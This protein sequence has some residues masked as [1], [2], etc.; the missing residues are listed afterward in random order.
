MSATRSVRFSRKISSPDTL[1]FIN[2]LIK[3]NTHSKTRKALNLVYS[4]MFSLIASQYV[5][6]KY[7]KITI[8]ILTIVLYFIG[9]KIGNQNEICGDDNEDL[10][11]FGT[12]N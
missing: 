7:S 1:M 5:P 11:N 10:T 2:D 6:S 4:A 9:R 8:G 12:K 3:K